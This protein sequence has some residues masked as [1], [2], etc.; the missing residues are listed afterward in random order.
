VV[1]GSLAILGM[2][3]L[4]RAA[5]G[6]PW[7]ALGASALMAADNLLLVHGRIG[8]L[9][10]YAVTAM[11]WAAVTYL[12]GR[13]AAA[14]VLVGVGACT[15]LVAPYVVVAF[16]LL[17]LLRGRSAGVRAALRRLLVCVAVAV[18]VF[19]GLLA[20]LDQI[21]PPYDSGHGVLVGGGVFGHISHILS[22]SAEQTSPRGATGI[23]SYPWQWLADFRPIV[24]LNVNPAQPAPGLAHVHPPVHFLGM[25]SPPILL[26]ALIGLVVAAREL[27]HVRGPR[28]SGPR[29][30]GVLPEFAIAWTVGTL[31]PFEALSAAFSRTSYLYYMVIVMPGLYVA[32]AYAL[33]RLPPGRRVVA[34]FVV[35]VVVA[36]VLMYPLTPLPAG[37]Q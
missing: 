14:G 28:R 27:W 24:Y 2:Y 30:P 13:P 7:T 23:Q 36:A 26:A 20:I 25:I 6:G 29:L 8:T 4:V 18:G 37:V 3:A 10:I 17:E 5:G 33:A 1:L 9:D 35:L 16:V 19:V 31:A 32:A 21:A 22:F 12:R 15:K 11:I 34:V